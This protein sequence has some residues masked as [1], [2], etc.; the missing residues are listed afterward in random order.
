[1]QDAERNRAENRHLCHIRKV[2]QGNELP[3][4]GGMGAEAK[5]ALGGK[6]LLT[7]SG[8]TDTCHW[9][10]MCIEDLRH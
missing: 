5:S 1:M 3:V 4:T 8:R 10:K 7:K 6:G 9:A 2:R